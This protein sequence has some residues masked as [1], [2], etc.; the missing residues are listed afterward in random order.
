MMRLCGYILCLSFIIFCIKT[1]AQSYNAIN[2]SAYAGVLGNFTN[3]ASGINTPFKWD[4]SILGAQSTTTNN[5][6]SVRNLNL[7]NVTSTAVLFQPTTGTGNRHIDNNADFHLVNIRYAID[8]I[9]CVSF[10]I[11]LRSYSHAAATSFNFIDTTSG[12]LPFLSYNAGSTPFNSTLTN[13]AWIENDFTYSRI[14]KEDNESRWSGGITLGILRGI[15]GVYGSVNN[16]RYVS[17]PNRSVARNGSVSILYSDTYS[18]TDEKNTLVN[19]AIQLKKASKLSLGASVGVEY[20]VKKNVFD[21][22]YNPKNYYWK[23]GLSIMD[24]GSNKFIT[25]PY[26]F[27]IDSPKANVTDT[28]LINQIDGAY[29]HYDVKRVLINNFKGTAPYQNTFK[30]RLPT[31][32]VLSIDKS[33]GTNFYVNALLS[34]NIYNQNSNNIYKTNTTE[35]SLLVLTPRWE[36]HFWGFYMPLQYTA[37]NN[38][39]IGT[40]IKIGP[41]LIGLHNVNWLDKSTIAAL[42]G[43]SYVAL[44]I[45]PKTQK[46]HHSLD[47]FEM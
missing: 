38:L 19:N 14:L 40:A 23:I 16:L 18:V 45:Q 9:Q 39:F 22:P 20:L 13:E 35:L 47:C 37:T 15:S 8:K 21:E 7:N 33:L 42:N 6:V 46:L 4:I 3:P 2:G 44:H 12:L 27:I 31:R 43:G 11:R 28:G 24:I 36:N 32:L 10:G 41:L 26:S 34:V 5:A 29:G 17:E 25:A 1:S 30:M